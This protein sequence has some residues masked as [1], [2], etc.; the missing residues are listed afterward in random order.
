M[1]CS[2]SRTSWLHVDC[3]RMA[4]TPVLSGGKQLHD[5]RLARKTRMV[6]F[7][8]GRFCDFIS[9]IFKPTH[10][11]ISPAYGHLLE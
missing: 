4:E 3:T 10:S 11:F 7:M 8:E 6:Q 1:L 9:F 5:F 2:P